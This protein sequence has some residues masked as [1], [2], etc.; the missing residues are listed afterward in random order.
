[1]RISANLFRTDLVFGAIAIVVAIS[2][3]LFG[4]VVLLEAITIPWYRA[5]RRAR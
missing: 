1:M 2:V 3:A 4:A 5:A